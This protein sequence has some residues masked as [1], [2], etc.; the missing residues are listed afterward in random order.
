MTAPT[1]F[2]AGPEAAPRGALARF[3]RVGT[4]ATAQQDLI[5]LLAE[6][7]LTEIV[8]SEVSEIVRTHGVSG[9]GARALLQNL[10]RDAVAEFIK[11]G[12]LSD[13]ELAYLGELRHVLSLSTTESETALDEAVGARYA[14]SLKEALAD[15]KLTED[16]RSRLDRLAQNLRLGDQSRGKLNRAHAQEFLTKQ[17]KVIVA[18]ERVTRGE[19]Q[20]LDDL[21]SALGVEIQ[22][23]SATKAS[24]ARY[25]RLWLIENGEPPSIPVDITL[26]K[27]EIAHFATFAR[28][29]ELRTK[30]VAVHYSGVSASIRIVKGVRWRVGTVTPHRVTKDQI[31]VIDSGMFY[32][33]N[34][35]ALFVGAK[36]NAA[37]RLNTLLGIQVFN[38]GIQLEKPTGRR[39][40]LLFDNEIEIAAAILTTLL[41]DS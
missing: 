40:Y 6:R 34:K 31:T 26:Q 7:P 32:I 14:K 25:Y 17:A 21:G 39:P 12:I 4:K 15:G 35:R 33:T 27:G 38:D 2:Q 24:L 29:A 37:I 22:F 3:F 19:L 1:P 10:W 23:D 11:D 5:N 16:E 13:D 36:K 20:E 41:A 9:R 8:P 30:T 28:W 18:D